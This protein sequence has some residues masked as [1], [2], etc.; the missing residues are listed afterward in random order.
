MKRWVSFGWTV[1]RPGTHLFHSVAIDWKLKSVCRVCMWLSGLCMIYFIIAHTH[2]LNYFWAWM[3]WAHIYKYECVYMFVCTCTNESYFVVSKYTSIT[4]CCCHLLF[5]LLSSD[6]FF[7]CFLRQQSDVN[8]KICKLFQS[9]KSFGRK[10]FI[11]NESN[12]IL[13]FVK[14]TNLNLNCMECEKLIK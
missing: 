1:P 13:F 3:I 6:V 7:H 9:C 14:K 5:T 4:K 11:I 10:F 2:S 12:F 8:D